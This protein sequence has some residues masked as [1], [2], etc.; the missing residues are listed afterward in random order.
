MYSISY[1][2][3][4]KPMLAC[5]SHTTTPISPDCIKTCPWEP[6]TVAIAYYQTSPSTQ[7]AI[8]VASVTQDKDIFEIQTVEAPPLLH[9]AWGKIPNNPN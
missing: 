1:Y 9:L 2:F 8:A 4:N 7:G 5:L 6:S 3:D